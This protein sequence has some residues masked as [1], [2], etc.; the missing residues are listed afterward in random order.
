MWTAEA[1]SSRRAWRMA[2]TASRR[3]DTTD[4]SI[5]LLLSSQI[6]GKLDLNRSNAL[7]AA[8]FLD[9]QREGGTV[10]ATMFSSLSSMKSAAANAAKKAR[11]EA[12]AATAT[13]TSNLAK[14]DD[15]YKVSST[16]AAQKK[17]LDSKVSALDDKYKITEKVTA[18]K[19]AIVERVAKVR[20]LVVT[21]WVVALH[22]VCRRSAYAVLSG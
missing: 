9:R 5:A 8:C 21:L 13:A 11:A 3:A 4:A 17:A 18:Q 10:L 22:P 2:L 7:K 15:K 19:E 12:A 1:S 14:L 20:S 6:G 16:M